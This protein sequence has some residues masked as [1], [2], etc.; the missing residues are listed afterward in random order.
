MATLFWLSNMKDLSKKLNN[1]FMVWIIAGFCC[2]LWGSA[3][4]FIKIGYKC[5]DI[6]S[7]DT[8][9]IILFAG[10]RFFL[11]GIITVFLFSISSKKLLVPKKKSASKI[12]SL[13]LFQTILQYLFFYL[14]LAYTTGVKA[15]IVNGTSTFIVLIISA[16]IFKQEK[17]TSLKMIG[18]ILGFLG[19]FVAGFFGSSSKTGLQIGDVFILLSAISY[20]FS[21]VL[22]KKYS[23]EENPAILSGYQFIVG[24]AVMTV[25]GLLFGATINTFN[26]KGIVVLVYLSF[27]SAIAYSLWS[28]LLKYNEVSKVTICG[29][30]TPIFGF[31]LSYVLLG[32]N[33]GN[34]LYNVLG[35]ICVVFGMV[36]VNLNAKKKAL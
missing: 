19:V 31:V 29:S 6:S 25:V 33:N 9:T 36:I 24:G 14:G 5:F 4:P 15:S 12:I 7:S 32:E 1:V 18:T 3:F 22:M 10:V 16:L 27:V 8:A 26:L 17:L 2:L 13:S 21:S 20:S 30:L 11:A 28:I 23:K 35:L 34:I